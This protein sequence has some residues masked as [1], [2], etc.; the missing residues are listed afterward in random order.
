MCTRRIDQQQASLDDVRTRMRA[1]EGNR[2][3]SAENSENVSGRENRT[4][5]RR[6]RRAAPAQGIFR[7]PMPR[8]PPPAQTSEPERVDVDQQAMQR[9]FVAY[10]QCVS[11]TNHVE[12]RLDQFRHAIQKDAL[13]LALVVH[14]H[15]QKVYGFC[16]E[17][18]QLTE[19][20][21]EAQAR[22][23][24]ID[25]L[26]QKMLQHEHHVNQTI[27]RNTHSQT[28]SIVAIIQEQEDLRK[29]VTELA[30][31]LDRSQDDFSTPQGEASTGILLEVG[32][33]KTKLSRLIEQHYRTRGRCVLSQRSA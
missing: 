18:R 11:R 23:T 14:G 2:E 33:L 16:Q 21:E 1:Q 6:R 7:S 26:A 17:L 12:N 4:T 29:L 5:D 30:S 8:T 31:R 25:N 19:S 9:L 13:D 22:I 28:A 32:D 15:D 24:G 20:V 3:W 27:D 10:D